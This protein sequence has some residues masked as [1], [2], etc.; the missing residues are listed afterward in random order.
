MIEAEQMQDRGVQVMHMHLVFDH[1]EAQVVALAKGDSWFDAASGHPHGEGVRVM[2]AAVV[3]AALDHRRAAELAA[4]QHQRVV[5]QAALLEIPDQRRARLVRILAVLLQAVDQVAVLVP[6]LVEQLDEAHAA[7]HQAPGEDAV[8][9]ERGLARFRS[10][11]LQHARR[12]LREIHQFRRAHLHP[13]RHL[14]RIDARLDLGIADF[15]VM[16]HVEP[17]DRVERIPLQLPV[18]PRR[19]REIQDRVAAGAELHA[20]VHRWQ[21]AAAPVGIAAAGPLLARTEHHEAGQVAGFAA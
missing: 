15:P 14:E 10:V 11:H 20:L 3:R 6:G 19:I 5:Q 9:G 18:Y 12:F 17:T 16:H 8:V 7:L 1:V 4:P 2:V 21:E 13:V